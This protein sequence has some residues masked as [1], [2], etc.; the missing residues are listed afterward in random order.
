M[1]LVL[2]Q[3]VKSSVRELEGS[4]IRVAAYASIRESPLTIEL[5]TEAL[6]DLVGQGRSLLT[7]EAIVK[8]VADYFQVKVADL[9]GPRRHHSLAWP[10]HR[11]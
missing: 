5:V 4:L 10:R 11:V 3:R 9:K 8:E 1:A 6:G 2:A 7:M